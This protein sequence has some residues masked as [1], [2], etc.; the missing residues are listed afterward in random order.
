MFISN[1]TRGLGRNFFAVAGACAIAA[2]SSSAPESN[3]ENTGIVPDALLAAACDT[4]GGNL[5]LSL[6]AGEVGYVGRTA[7]CTVE[8]CVFANAV[9]SSGAICR[10]SSIGKTITVT[11]AAGVEKMVVDYSA[12]LFA[13]ATTST[14]LVSITLGGAGSKLMIVAPNAGSNMAL[15]AT[16]LDT[17]TLASRTPARVDVA[18]A[19]NID[20]LFNGGTGADV[21]T[22]DVAGWAPVAILPKGWGTAATISAVTG[23]AFPGSLTANGGA[24]DDVLAGGAGSNTLLGGAGND[25]FLQGSVFHPEIMNG[26]DG[27]DIVDYSARTAPVGVSVGINAAVATVTATGASTGTGYTVGDVLTLAGGKLSPATVTVA[28]ATGG[29]INTV[30]LTTPGSGYAAAAGVTATGGT[31]TGATFAIATLKSDDG[32]VATAEGDSVG[33]NIEIVKGGSGNDILN[34]YAV[35]TTDVVLLGNAGDDKLTGGSGNDDLCGGA[36]DDTFYENVGN[37]NLVGGAGTDTADYSGGTGVVACLGAADQVAG[38]PCATQNGATGEKDVVNATLAKVCPRATLT[39]DVGGVATPAV[40]VPA[41]IQ[42]AAMAIDVENLTGTASASN[43][44][45]CGTLAC[46]LF[47][48]SA[49]DTLWGGAATDIIVGKGGADTVK[50]NGSADLVDFTH[51]GAGVIQTLDCHSDAVTVLIPTVDTQTF[52]ACSIANIP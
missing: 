32:D 30:T 2:C 13:Q 37:D 43:A 14:P 19:T 5:T 8:P 27:I 48:G 44:L 21:F 20:V 49:A 47:G 28:T 25:T 6:A 26:G 45:Y 18:I 24:G 22:G 39:A 33:A 1:H 12:G 34:A 46:T 42:G 10:V 36:G 4:T 41:A 3:L 38:K 15:G 51:A 50:T 29:V 40:A 16:G 17:N 52:T 31:G 11:G 9:T 23:A 35:T 7:G